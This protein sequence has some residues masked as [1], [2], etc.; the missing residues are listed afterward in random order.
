MSAPAAHASPALSREAYFAAL[1][2]RH[3]AEN[4]QKLA[5]ARVG[6]A[7]LGGLGSAIACHLARLGVGTLV[8][9][10]FDV[11]DVSNLHRQQYTCAQVGM[12]KTEALAETLRAINPFV[13]LELHSVK[14]TAE[15]ASTLFAGCPIV[16]EAFDE[17][18]QK[19]LLVETLL[20][21]CPDTTIV[22]G[23]GM[24][25]MRSANTIHTRKALERLYLCGDGCT[26]VAAEGSLASP[27]VGVC[28]GHQANM[29]LRLILGETEP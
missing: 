5:H 20:A 8:L 16:C 10:D 25:G 3:G 27:R 24:A 9:V 6:I 7:G 14:V 13:G 28:A 4:Q 21:T 23:S 17:P 19:A 15:N 26:D 11:V 29:V 1:A 12:K 22:S 2:K 18:D